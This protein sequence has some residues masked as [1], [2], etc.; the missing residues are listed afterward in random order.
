MSEAFWRSSTP[1]S[2]AHGSSVGSMKIAAPR[3]AAQSTAD[4]RALRFSDPERPGRIP[5]EDAVR[6]VGFAFLPRFLSSSLSVKRVSQ[7]RGRH[8]P[9]PPHRG[10][11]CDS[12]WSR[13]SCVLFGY[14]FVV[15]PP[16]KAFLHSRLSLRESSAVGGVPSST[17]AWEIERRFTTPIAGG[18]HVVPPTGVTRLRPHPAN[19]LP[20]RTATAAVPAV[21]PNPRATPPRPDSS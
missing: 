1:D 9:A 6:R 8:G 11:F 7:R 20:H 17:R 12:V 19:S 18:S 14:S 3:S 13:S 4:C 15:T 10:P 16:C 5:K 21:S 2:T